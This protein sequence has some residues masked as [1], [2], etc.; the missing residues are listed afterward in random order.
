M[1]AVVIL[2]TY[3]EKENIEKLIPLLEEEVFPKVKNHKMSILVADDSSPDGTEDAVRH[4]MKKYKNLD[5]S[6]GHK[7]GLGAAYIRGM[8]Y[9]IEHMGADVVFEMDADGQHDPEKIPAF[10]DKI[11]EGSDMVIGTRYSGGGSI[12]QNWPPQ[13]KMF[14]IV[15]NILVR[16]IFMKFGVHDWTGG[17]RALKKEVFLKEREKL[18]GY[19][20]YI[21]QIAF[22][23]M[24]IADGF[25]I[26]EV[27]FHFS[28]RKL[29][30]SKIAPLG[31]I[32]DV[33]YFVISARIKELIFGKF[34]KFLVVGGIGFVINFVILKVLSDTYHFDHSIANLVGA[35]V[36]IF[37]NY[38]FNNI[39]T[40]KENKVHGVTQYFIKMAQFYLTSVFGVIFIQTG[41]IFLGDRF[42]GEGVLR[43]IL[44]VKYYYIYFVIGT[45]L[46]LIWNFVM[47]SMFIW[48]KHPKK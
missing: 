27:P 15:A 12:P 18:S 17:Y 30:Q 43:V 40:F 22:L 47:Y 24:A 16:T 48:K 4:L 9:A 13:R 7:N 46:L 45:G 21:F 25:R 32:I 19:N 35:A 5:V 26:G 10:L 39:W 28:D 44:P 14:S 11:D 38:N 42:I 41:T 33:L 36:A 37:S 23:H 34:G 29:G 1:H 31:Y 20:G 2:P 6:S 8:N 3:N